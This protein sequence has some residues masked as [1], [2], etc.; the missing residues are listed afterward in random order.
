MTPGL[1]GLQIHQYG[2]IKNGFSSVGSLFNPFNKSHG[3]PTDEERT[4]GDLGNVNANEEGT[5]KIDLKD[6]ILRLNGPFSI[7]GR[8]IVIHSDQDDLGTGNLVTF[9]FYT[10]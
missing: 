6:K 10:L 7:I 5:A 8:S 9:F 2:D 4:V 1:H 3:A